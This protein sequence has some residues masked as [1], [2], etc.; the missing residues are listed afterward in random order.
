ME[1][2]YRVLASSEID[3]RETIP[4]EQEQNIEAISRYEKL[5]LS[6]AQHPDDLL[7]AYPRE[8]DPRAYVVAVDGEIVAVNSRRSIAAYLS[9]RMRVRREATILVH[10]LGGR[11]QSGLRD[12]LMDL[13]LVS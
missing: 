1:T 11:L 3:V 10:C 7:R 9:G 12:E 4:G 6:V 5:M 13:V 8:D 2:T